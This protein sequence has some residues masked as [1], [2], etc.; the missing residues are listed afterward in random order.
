MRRSPARNK[1][2]FPID[3]VAI[4]G[5]AINGSILTGAPVNGQAL[6]NLAVLLE[7]TCAE[8]NASL[9]YNG[10]LEAHPTADDCTLCSDKAILVQLIV[11]E[12]V[13]NASKYA[14]PT[15]SPDG[16]L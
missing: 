3:G 12:A 11:R 9:R 2:R 14:H 10:R 13:T 1:P 5:K 15:G 4:Q 8:L 16:S 7:R 6:T